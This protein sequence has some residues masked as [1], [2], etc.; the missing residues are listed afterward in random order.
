MFVD[1]IVE[2]ARKSW[3]GLHITGLKPVQRHRKTVFICFHV[4]L[5]KRSDEKWRIVTS[6]HR[7]KHMPSF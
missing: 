7:R 4:M 3:G 2:V 1:Q 6:T 5:R